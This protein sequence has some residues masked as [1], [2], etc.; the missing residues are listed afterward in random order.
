MGMGLLSILPGV[1]EGG[2]ECVS[3]DPNTFGSSSRWGLRVIYRDSS[4]SCVWNQSKKE[5]NSFL[6]QTK[7]TAGLLFSGRVLALGP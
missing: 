7:E 1:L 2:T 6:F 3:T 4:T 5:T